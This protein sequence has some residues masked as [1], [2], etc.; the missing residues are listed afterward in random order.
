MVAEGAVLLRVEHLEHRA[1]RIPAEV[2]AHLVDLV[3][4]QHRVQRLRVAQRADDRS[5]HRADVRATVAPDLGL[6][7]HAADGEP[8]ELPLERAR[9]RLAE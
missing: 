8:D 7:A 6:V 2:G 4:E 3:D 1:R 5:R 9:D